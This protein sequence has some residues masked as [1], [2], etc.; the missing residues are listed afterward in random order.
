M[1]KNRQ[2]GKTLQFI[3]SHLSKKS[4]CLA[5]YA[6]LKRRGFAHALLSADEQS[7]R[8]IMLFD[9]KA[10]TFFQTAYAA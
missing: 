5:I 2:K 10:K 6:K 3:R 9:V 1:L 7:T 8:F 4:L